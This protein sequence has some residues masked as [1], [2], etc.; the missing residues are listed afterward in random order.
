MLLGLSFPPFPFYGLALVALVPLIARW[1]RLPAPGVLFRETYSAFLI[2]A[3]LSG[4]WVLLH[5]DML[6]ALLLGLGILTIPLLHALPV[7]GS[8]YVARRFGLAVGLPTLLLGWLGLEY[9]LSHSPMALPWLLLGHTQAAALTF[10][11]FA[12]VLGVGGLS[13][14][15]L[16]VNVAFFGLIQARGLTP[17]FALV[18]GAVA[19]IVAPVG[20]RA[21]STT[22]LP[23][24]TDT[25]H[26]AVVQPVLSPEEWSAI[27]SADRVQM[28]ADQA[29]EALALLSPITRS[30]VDRPRLI[31][32][33]EAA[34]P[35]FPEQ[36][37]QETLYG[38]VSQ[39]ANRRN[40][41]LLTGAVTR[42]DTAPALTVDPFDAR[43]L[44]ATRPYYNS[45][46]LFDNQ[47]RAQQYDKIQLLPGA[48]QVPLAGFATGHRT[49]L[50]NAFGIGGQR[51]IFRAAGSR[52]ASL[53]GYEIYFGDHARQ[54]VVEGAEFLTLLSNTGWWD[55]PAAT[56]QYEAIAR[57]RAIE[58]RRSVVISSVSGGSGVIL[59]DGTSL[60]NTGW[61]ERTVMT[62]EVPR[63]TH[64]T[65]YAMWGDVVYR[66]GALGTLLTLL[67]YGGAALFFP[68][69]SGARRRRQRRAPARKPA[70]DFSGLS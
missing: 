8:S 30:R 44:A 16:L 31:I 34:L 55:Y 57:L 37:L 24:S 17:R 22:S 29:D 19:M 21:W 54:M 12:D 51:T 70:I 63:Y 20:Y 52:F 7:V 43:Q 18:L 6:T 66:V 59:P 15:V 28:L 3:V 68:G 50:G 2:F 38:R 67:L 36:R 60:S 5:S 35:V 25:L 56:G 13:L 32:W 48:D 41:A 69:A 11:Q 61:G 39:W 27:A 65:R 1:S 53:I 47:Q 58:N 9:V 62:A 45:A 42:Y 64:L 49:A 10:N 40:V 23:P 46:L 4:Y 33:P 14:W 26:V